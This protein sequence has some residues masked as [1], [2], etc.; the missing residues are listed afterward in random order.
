[1]LRRAEKMYNKSLFYDFIFYDH[2]KSSPNQTT[3]I[4]A[5][6]FHSNLIHLKAPCIFYDHWLTDWMNIMYRQFWRNCFSRYWSCCWR[7]QRR[8]SDIIWKQ[9]VHFQLISRWRSTFWTQSRCPFWSPWTWR[10]RWRDCRQWRTW[11]TGRPPLGRSLECPK[12]LIL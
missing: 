11:Q 10:S 2:L 5:K 3:T 9:V 8:S 12:I 4:E 1:M 6:D 7:D